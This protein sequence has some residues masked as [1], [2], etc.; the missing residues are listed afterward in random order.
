[1]EYEIEID[2][3]RDQVIETVT[4]RDLPNEFSG[5][6]EAKGMHMTVKKHFM[7][8]GPDKTRWVSENEAKV[9]GFFM[10]LMTI[11]MPNCFRNVSFKY[12]KNFKAY[13]ETGADVRKPAES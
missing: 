13:A 3:P 12:M 6:F 1:M 10:R 11:V 2:L 8:A 4:V 5:T 9:S 7:K